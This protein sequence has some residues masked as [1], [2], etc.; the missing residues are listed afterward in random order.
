MRLTIPLGLALTLAVG[1]L[2]AQTVPVQNELDAL[3]LADQVPAKAETARDWQ[4]S[5]EGALGQSTL[6][7]GD[8][9]H[10]TERLS[11]DFSL[12]KTLAKGWRVVLS[13]QL[14][15]RWQRRL[16][17]Q[18]SV[19]TLREA[20]LSWQP[21]AEHA[22]DVGRINARYG[23]AYGYNPTDFFRAGAN[24]SIVS[25]D[26]NTL[27]KNRQG[28]VMLRAQTL[29]SG[30]A[31]T[32]M[33]SPKLAEQRNDGAF[34]LDLGATNAQ[35]RW[36]IAVSEQLTPNINPQWLLFG[37]SGQSPQLGMNLTALLGEATVAHFEWSGARSA[38]QL[39]QA[40]G[41]VDDTAFRTR[42]ASGLS[43]TTENKLA[44]TAEY[45]FNGAAPDGAVWDALAHR[46]LGAYG[47]YRQWVQ[48]RFDLP[49]RS[50]GFLYA[51]WQDAML[52][53][54]DVNAMLRV[55][56]DDHS[57]LAWLELRYHWEHA[58]LGL[59]WQHQSGSPASEF[60]ALPQRHVVQLLGKYFF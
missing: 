13:D 58:D 53:H 18:T 36:L 41:G 23:V 47:Q 55:N 12:D 2:Q 49:T 42:L 43:Y 33:L 52:N 17:D 60:G 39:R 26:P 37:A 8:D 48:N 32:A 11:F 3:T 6:R 1:A 34:N 19:N 4:A 16:D 35:D 14:D 56:L 7:N 27:K 38:S 45:E 51:S 50:S 44:L 24:R 20:Y 28:S 9:G 40:L 15:L 31:L 54:F 59:Q 21:Q 22:L 5:V 46:S 25:L 30:G 29:W 57:R 10:G